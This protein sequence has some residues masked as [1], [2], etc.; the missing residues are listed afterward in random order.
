MNGPMERR[1]E[2]CWCEID[3]PVGPLLLA[4]SARGLRQLHFRGGPGAAAVP[5]HW[6]ADPQALQ[7]A[8]TQLR[9]YFA[10]TRRVF[11]VP[12]DLRGTPFQLAVWRALQQIPYGVTTSYGLLARELGR[13]QGARAVG[14]A[15]GAN[16]VP[17][18]VPCHRVIGANGTLTG[19]GGG[20]PV[21]RAL[22]Q[23]EGAACVRDLFAAAHFAMPP[24]HG[25][26]A[27]QD[28]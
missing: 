2:T 10:G 27:P 26:G 3:S 14:L 4:G 24:V 16:P 1:D 22:L 25:A 18:I 5:A 17:I 9:E 21:K 7:A 19:F 8:A 23:L 20:L 13:P 6:R 11:E 15:N 28:R 12:L